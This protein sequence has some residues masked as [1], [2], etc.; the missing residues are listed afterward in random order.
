[1]WKFAV[2]SRG[3]WQT[4]FVAV[5]SAGTLVSWTRRLVGPCM[6]AVKES[7]VKLRGT[8]VV[9]SYKIMVLLVLVPLFNV[10]YGALFG[11]LFLR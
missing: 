7:K 9:A 8:D 2:S 4:R 1:M 11:L 3:S 10:I 5:L 6:Q